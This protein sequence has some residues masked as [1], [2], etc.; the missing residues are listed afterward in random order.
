M[1][2]ELVRGGGERKQIRDTVEANGRLEEAWMTYQGLQ[3]R[4][5]SGTAPHQHQVVRRSQLLLNE[6]LRPTDCV[7]D[8]VDAPLAAQRLHVGFAVARA[9]TMIDL[10][11]G[12][13]ARGKK[14]RLRVKAGHRL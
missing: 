11:D 8:I 6:I 7:L 5:A 10:Q 1:G 2:F 14:L 12:V 4:I 9:A 3:N 13:A